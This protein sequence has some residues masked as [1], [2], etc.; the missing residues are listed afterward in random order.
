[1]AYIGLAKPTVA[2]LSESEGT[3]TYSDG[4]AC[5]KAIEMSITPT[6]A[7]GSLYGDN[8]KAEYDKEFSYAE[9]TLNTSTIPMKAHD[10]MFGHT[11]NEEEGEI[12]EKAGDEAN[13]IGL[14]IYAS[15]KVD[16][17]KK[18]VAM[19][20]YKAKFTESEESYTTKGD[21]IEYQTPSITGQAVALETGEWRDRKICDTEKEAIAWI[22]EKAGIS[23]IGG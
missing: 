22:E 8:I 16:G 10:V 18:Y 11:V 4:F 6:Y 13:Y 20:I 2:K 12:K 7:E 21:S 1:M 14:G 17:V 3:P 19:W 15:E 23:E 5:G 9:I